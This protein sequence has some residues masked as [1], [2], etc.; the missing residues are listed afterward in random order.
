MSPLT[1]TPTVFFFLPGLN[2]GADV[3]SFFDTSSLVIEMMRYRSRPPPSPPR[4]ASIASMLSGK[5][6]LRRAVSLPAGKSLPASPTASAGEPAAGMQAPPEQQ[7]AMYS[8]PG[9][10]RNSRPPAVTTGSKT[11]TEFREGKV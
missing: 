11:T 2:R 6:F 8:E 10:S 1:P 3:R 9:L 5:P 4:A 7:T